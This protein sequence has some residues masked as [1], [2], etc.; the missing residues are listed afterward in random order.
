[1]N[2]NYTIKYLQNGFIMRKVSFKTKKKKNE[3]LKCLP[4]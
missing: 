1:M 2:N 3:C 4:T